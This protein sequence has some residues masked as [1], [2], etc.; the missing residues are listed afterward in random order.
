MPSLGFDF[1]CVLAIVKPCSCLGNLFYQAKIICLHES[2]TVASLQY[3]EGFE[4]HLLDACP[5]AVLM[6]LSITSPGRHLLCMC[7]EGGPDLCCSFTTDSFLYTY[8]FLFF[9]RITI[10]F[11]FQGKDLLSG[12]EGE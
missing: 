6:S 1:L 8:S 4:V 7:S 12:E 9:I 11:L 10:F 2:C 5:S 3:L